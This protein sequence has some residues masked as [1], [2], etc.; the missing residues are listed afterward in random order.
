LANTLRWLSARL[1][2]ASSEA[3]SVAVVCR[4][5]PNNI[6]RLLDVLFIVAAD[7]IDEKV[8]Q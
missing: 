1:P 7:R 6:I 2:P 4:R 5:R 8:L 3:S